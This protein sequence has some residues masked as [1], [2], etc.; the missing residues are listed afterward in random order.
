MKKYQVLFLV[1]SLLIVH[2]SFCFAIRPLYTEDAQVTPIG[3]L[4]VE[5][6]LLLLTNRDNTG[7]KE[8]VTSLKYG[9]AQNFDA[10]LDLPYMSRL[11][12]GD[13]YDGLGDGAVKIKYNFYSADKEAAS[14]MIG[15]LPGN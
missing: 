9:F 10:S 12:T 13:N 3:K 7:V 14:F 6:G 15:Y 11:S 1:L 4:Y 8:L 5:S 2:C